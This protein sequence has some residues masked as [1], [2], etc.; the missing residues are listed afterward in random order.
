VISD[1]V[2]RRDSFAGTFCLFFS[3]FLLRCRGRPVVFAAVLCLVVCLLIF[4]GDSWFLDLSSV[5][6]WAVRWIA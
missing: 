6:D 3:V 4:V 2:F 1:G 5:P